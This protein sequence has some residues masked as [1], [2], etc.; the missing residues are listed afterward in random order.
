MS[1]ISQYIDALNDEIR[2]GNLEADSI[3]KEAYRRWQEAKLT[4]HERTQDLANQI[5]DH[6]AGIGPNDRKS[7][8]D[9]LDREVARIGRDCPI[10]T[11]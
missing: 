6:A 10:L 2:T 9:E 11:L 7:L 8:L 5:R 1:L 3:H 4:K